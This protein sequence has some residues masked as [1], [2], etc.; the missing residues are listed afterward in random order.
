[1]TFSM[2][3]VTVSMYKWENT[4]GKDRFDETITEDPVKVLNIDK[5][6]VI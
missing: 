2:P 6:E 3:I 4:E 5:K 1:M